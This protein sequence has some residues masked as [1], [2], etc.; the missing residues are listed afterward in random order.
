MASEENGKPDA[1]QEA[2]PEAAREGE[3]AQDASQQ[4]YESISQPVPPI[5]FTTFVLSLSTSALVHLGE[6][7]EP[8]SQPQ[9]N[10]PM[11][12]QT[13]DLLGLLE[14]KT[15]GNLTGEEERLLHQV[16]FDLRMRFVA[17]NKQEER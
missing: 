1:R 6:A 3:A 16:L 11:A 4:A 10:L 8:G 2:E 15:R 9:V 12:R 17:R 5:D 13:I 14:D 7:C